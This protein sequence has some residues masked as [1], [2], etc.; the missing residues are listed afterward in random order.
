MEQ[1]RWPNTVNCPLCNSD[2]V[3]KMGGDTQTGMWVCYGCKGKFTVRTG[4]VFER[5]AYPVAQMAF[6]YAPDGLKQEG[7]FG[8]STA[9]DA[10]GDLQNRVVYVPSHPRGHETRRRQSGATWAAEGKI[11]EA[12]E[13][14]IGRKKGREA[15][16][17]GLRT[18]TC[19]WL[20]PSLNAADPCARSTST[21]CMNKKVARRVLFEQR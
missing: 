2:N 14:F 5:S 13:T 6:G 3:H 7:H 16:A 20:W 21:S 8:P 4:T 9:P 1:D 10:K 15:H 19:T 17:A 11:I 12:D 18:I